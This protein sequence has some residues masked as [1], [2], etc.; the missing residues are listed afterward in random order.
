[1]VGLTWILNRGQFSSF[2]TGHAT[3]MVSIN[4]CIQTLH[5]S[6]S[7]IAQTKLQ[8]ITNNNQQQQHLHRPF[9]FETS[10]LAVEACSHAE[11][12]YWIDDQ[13]EAQLN[14][15]CG[16]P[17]CPQSH[18][19]NHAVIWE[20]NAV[21]RQKIVIPSGGLAAVLAVGHLSWSVKLCLSLYSKLWTVQ[22]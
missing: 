13:Q 16:R 15:R 18:K 7:Y 11:H 6:V 12:H 3:T 20:V 19:Y 10:M 4:F 8:N 14:A 9:I 2:S 22:C 1:M 21:G 5:R 17:Y